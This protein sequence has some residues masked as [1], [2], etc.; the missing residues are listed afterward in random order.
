MIL[1]KL[2]KPF[3][4]IYRKL[5]RLKINNDMKNKLLNDKFTIFS[6]NCTGGVISHDLGCRFYSPTVNFYFMAKD[7]VRFFPI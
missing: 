1:D 3:R 5:Y 4:K 2:M 6:S 7:Y